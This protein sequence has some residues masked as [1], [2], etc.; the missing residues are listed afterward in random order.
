MGRGVKKMHKE[1]KEAT[2]GGTVLRERAVGGKASIS[3][4]HAI[5]F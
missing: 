3:N 4:L 2:I 1:K 5:T